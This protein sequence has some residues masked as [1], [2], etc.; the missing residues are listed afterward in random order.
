MSTTEMKV[1]PEPAKDMRA[2]LMRENQEG[3]LIQGEGDLTYLCGS[4]GFALLKDM[5]N[6]RVF[7]DVVFKCP[8][9]ESF[10]EISPAGE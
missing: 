8:S 6:G 10:N 3:P 5:D 2:V 1:I 7:V 9:C 4:C